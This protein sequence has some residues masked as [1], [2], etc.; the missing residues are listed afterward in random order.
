[1]CERTSRGKASE[2]D[3]INTPAGFILLVRL[4][5]SLTVAILKTNTVGEN[6]QKEAGIPEYTINTSLHLLFS[7]DYPSPPPLSQG[8]TRNQLLEVAP[9]KWKMKK[10]AG[11]EGKICHA[12][13]LLV[14][15]DWFHPTPPHSSHV[16]IT[17]LWGWIRRAKQVWRDRPYTRP[18][19]PAKP[20][21]SSATP[22]HSVVSETQLLTMR[23][24]WS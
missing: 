14:Q 8:L 18:K 9:K 23:W 3:T 7:L 4:E 19:N 10:E 2:E 17:A 13:D 5:S 20:D 15:L 11:D 12:P 1:M 21:S 24:S 16:Q 22:L 6:Q